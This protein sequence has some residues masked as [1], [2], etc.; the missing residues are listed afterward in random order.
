[1]SQP[2]HSVGYLS[3]LGQRTTTMQH[4]LGRK[5]LGLALIFLCKNSLFFRLFLFLSDHGGRA[6]ALDSNGGAHENSHS[7]RYHNGGGGCQPRIPSA[8]AQTFFDGA[9]GAG[10][11]RLAFKEGAEVV[12]QIAGGGVA[13]AG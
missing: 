8:P 10:L 1:M 13:S 6:S 2:E 5:S 12:G 9:D 3:V 4:H 7:R 11:D